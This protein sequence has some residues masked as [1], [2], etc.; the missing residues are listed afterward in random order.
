[1]VCKKPSSFRYTTKSTSLKKIP[2]SHLLVIVYILLSICCILLG[3][4]A[5]S[6]VISEYFFLLDSCLVIV[7]GL[8]VGGILHFYWKL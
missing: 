2:I 4:Y 1:M 3:A 7:S 5:R 6:S 8:E